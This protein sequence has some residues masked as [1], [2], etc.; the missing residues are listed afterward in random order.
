MSM[1]LSCS[2]TKSNHEILYMITMITCPELSGYKRPEGGNQ[3]C[4]TVYL[5]Q[6]CDGCDEEKPEPEKQIE[7][8]VNHIVRKNTDCLCNLKMSTSPIFW[9]RAEGDQWQGSH[10]GIFPTVP[11][12]YRWPVV[13]KIIVQETI[14]HVYL[15]KA[16]KKAEPFTNTELESIEFIATKRVNVVD[17]KFL[18]ER[19]QIKKLRKFGHMSKL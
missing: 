16:D 4:H 7:L 18:R 10:H 9:Q 14:S 17:C 13:E 1:S 8:P 11:S 3:K 6:D 15:D 19:S 2:V 5:M 12:Q